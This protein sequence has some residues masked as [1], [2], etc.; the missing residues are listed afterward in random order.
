MNAVI[1]LA[2]VALS[3]TYL[4]CRATLQNEV[5]VWTIRI[6]GTQARPVGSRYDRIAVSQRPTQSIASTLTQDRI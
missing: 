4:D 3:T 2:A 1:F 5:R 6:E